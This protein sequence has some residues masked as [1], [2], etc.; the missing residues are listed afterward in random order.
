MITMNYDKN[1]QAA[2]MHSYYQDSRR[3][4][5]RSDEDF[6]FFLHCQSVHGSTLLSCK[7]D[8]NSKKAF[9]YLN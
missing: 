3:K 9:K 2:Y 6:I 8:K 1:L 7:P 5:Q 4:K